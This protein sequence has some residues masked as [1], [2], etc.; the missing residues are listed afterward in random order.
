MKNCLNC[1]HQ[2]E[3]G[4]WVKHMLSS[5]WR[6]GDCKY[7]F[8]LPDLPECVVV[9]TEMIYHY[10][11][12]IKDWGIKEKCPTWEPSVFELEE[13]GEGMYEMEPVQIDEI[14]DEPEEEGVFDDY[15]SC[16]DSNC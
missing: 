7:K 5:Q 8:S 11:K 4:E 15:I 1:K 3:W 6:R 16:A 9:K 10:N 2:P 12:G 14:S 13:D